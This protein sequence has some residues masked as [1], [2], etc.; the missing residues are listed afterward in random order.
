MKGIL[1]E[2][3]SILIIALFLCAGCHNKGSVVKRMNKYLV[4]KEI[5]FDWP[6]LFVCKD[7][8][9]SDSL[10]QMTPVKIIT[11]RGDESCA[12]CINRLLQKASSF[13]DHGN[14]FELFNVSQ[15][16]YYIILSRPIKDIIK[17]FQDEDIPFV[18]IIFDKNDMFL[19]NNLLSKNDF[20]NLTLLLDE[21]NRIVLVGDPIH[22]EESR[23][24][25]V[26]KIVEII[27][28]YNK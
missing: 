26:D 15:V 18:S 11:Y 3:F 22:D 27:T 9:I 6:K 4:G 14:T 19:D 25:Y 7:S 1:A 5:S 16:N 12:L 24:K 8:I 10:F 23:D 2:F 28:K 20:S 21:N 17:C 13:L